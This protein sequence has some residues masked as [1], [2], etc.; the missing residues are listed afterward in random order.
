M[1]CNIS[2]T[3]TT[4]KEDMFGN[5]DEDG[6]SIDVKRFTLTSLGGAVVQ[7]IEYGATVTS[8]RV[9][10]RERNLVN[11][12]MGFDTLDGTT[13]FIIIVANT[14]VC[15]VVNTSSHQINKCWVL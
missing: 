9:P 1:L 13:N 4:I 2:D 6:T 5:I 10:D 11:V 12:T 15:H 14:T 7:I 3:M 8:I